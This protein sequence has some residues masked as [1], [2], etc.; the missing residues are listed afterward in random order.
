VDAQGNLW[1]YKHN[2]YL[3]GDPSWEQQTQV[4]TGWN[5]FS[6]IFANAQGIIYGVLLQEVSLG[7]MLHPERFLAGSLPW[8]Q[9]LGFATGD[10]TWNGPKQVGKDWDVFKSVFSDGN[11]IICGIVN[12]TN[13]VYAKG[14]L[15]RYKHL[16]QADGSFNW[17]ETKKINN[18]SWDGYSRAFIRIP[19]PV[20]VH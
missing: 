5:I 9:H 1:W 16:G 19:L 8:Y 11:D 20:V 10:N 18:W 7:T 13:G 4:G 6:S 2:G 14:D 3:T 12:Q 15:L 17:E